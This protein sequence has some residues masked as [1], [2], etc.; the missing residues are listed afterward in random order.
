M[1]GPTPKRRRAMRK[2]TRELTVEYLDDNPNATQDEVNAAVHKQLVDEYG[3][4]AVGF[5]P[6]II[7]LIVKFIMALMETW[8][9]ND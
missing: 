2:L 4:I 9:S 1:P 3:D 8:Q 5:N 7:M 6:A